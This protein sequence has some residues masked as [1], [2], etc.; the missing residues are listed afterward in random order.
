MPVLGHNSSRLKG[1]VYRCMQSATWL[2]AA[3]WMTSHCHCVPQ[4]AEEGQLYL[5][6]KAR[7]IQDVLPTRLPPCLAATRGGG[8]ALP[9]LEWIDEVGDAWQTEIPYV[10]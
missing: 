8:Q 3:L 2:T 5:L 6:S 7:C 9:E 10:T 4:L 1:A